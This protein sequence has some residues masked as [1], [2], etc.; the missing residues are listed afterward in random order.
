M[1]DNDIDVT[2]ANLEPG[3]AA[4]PP[5][6]AHRSL[7]R[8]LSAR[9][10]GR[11]R[12]VG[13]LALAAIVALIGGGYVVGGP[14]TGATQSN[15]P[16]AALADKQLGA[17]TAAPP[18]PANLS[19]DGSGTGAFAGVGVP[20]VSTDQGQTSGQSQVVAAVD[21]SQIVK[22]GQLDLEVNDLNAALSQAKTAITRLGGTVDQSSQSGTGT[23]ATASVTYR[24]PAAR[25]DDALTALHKIGTRVISEQ[26][27]ATDVTSQVIDLN[28]RLANLDATETA[29]QSIMTRATAIADVLA[30]EAQLSDTQGQIEELTAERDHLANQAAMST[31][32]V[33]F[34]LPTATVTAQ[35]TEDWT[36]ASQVDQAGAALVRIGQGLA[37]MAVWVVVVVLPLALGA[38]IL[39][40]IFWVGRRLAGR[41]RR[42]NAVVEA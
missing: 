16:R 7:G 39:F 9:F 8:T 28:A 12:V 41:G 22:T 35:A 3:E 34:Q 26:T 19:A 27:G 4:D 24:V 15:P 20:G 23:D 38:L 25:W 30:V 40:G 37:T 6:G 32:T 29:L 36:L 5:P 21:A 1:A 33:T 42:R 13:G 18:A 10:D 2:D 14:P 31:L 17:A 11:G